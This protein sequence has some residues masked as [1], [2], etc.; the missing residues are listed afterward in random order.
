VIADNQLTASRGR[1]LSPRYYESG[2]GEFTDKFGYKPTKQPRLLFYMTG[3]YYGVIL[4]ERS[5]LT[6][7]IP[8]ASDVIAYRDKD[9]PQKAWFLLVQHNGREEIY[10]SDTV[11]NPCVITP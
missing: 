3:D 6:E 7:F 5:Q 11:D 1:A 9:V 8:H 2:E 4:L 10:F